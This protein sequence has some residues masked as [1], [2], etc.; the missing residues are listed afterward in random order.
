MIAIDRYNVVVYP[1]NPLRS[2]TRIRSRFMICIVWIYSL[3]FATPPLLEI[4]YSKYVPEGF[5]TSCSFDYLDKTSEARIFM[6]IYFIFAWVVPFCLITYCYIHILRVVISAK[7]IQS[8]KEKNK[9]EIKLALVVIGIIFLWFFAWTP[10][11]I[12]ALLGISNNERFLTPLGSMIPAILCKISAAIDPYFYAVT[13]PRFR[14]ELRRICGAKCN[15]RRNSQIQTSFCSRGGTLR[16]RGIG[17]SADNPRT[18]RDR[19]RRANSIAESSISASVDYS[20]DMEAITLK[21]NSRF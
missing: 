16:R 17:D 11:A 8:N 7:R 5:L 18:K 10:Y 19:L 20:S 1:L 15:S 2:T 12:V 4:G 21:C 6:F 9:T 14:A 13:H 3:V